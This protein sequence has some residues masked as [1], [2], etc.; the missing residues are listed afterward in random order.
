MEVAGGQAVGEN[1]RTFLSAQ[2]EK[3]AAIFVVDVENRRAGRLGATTFEEHALRGKV[4]VHRAMVVEMITREVGEDCNIEGNRIDAFLFECVGRDLHN[5]FGDAFG[6]SLSQKLVEFER[7]RGGVRCGKNSSGNVVFD[8][9]DKDRFASGG[10][11]NRFDQK[12]RGAFA[13]RASNAGV[14][15][16]FGGTLVEVGAEAG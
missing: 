14:Y 3:L 15:D 1:L 13:V 6:E 4:F 2:T 11:K 12:R 5:R 9:A 7:F 10:A 8:C 16:A